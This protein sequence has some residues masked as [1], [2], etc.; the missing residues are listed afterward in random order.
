[1]AENSILTGVNDTRAFL[2]VEATIIIA[3]FHLSLR[4][5]ALLQGFHQIV[6]IHPQICQ[7]PPLAIPGVRESNPSSI[8]RSL[9]L[10]QQGR[11]IQTPKE[12]PESS[13]AYGGSLKID[14]HNQNPVKNPR[15]RRNVPAQAP[16]SL[17]PPTCLYLL[18]DF[19]K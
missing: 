3:K 8:F 6:S 19:Y 7:E 9:L 15:K 14:S 11:K 16:Q 2:S 13:W 4:D 18:L 12:A 1:M 17:P 10:N 5:K